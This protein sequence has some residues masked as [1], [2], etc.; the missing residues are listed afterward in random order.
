M[1]D[2]LL[3]V[4]GHAAARL[5]LAAGVVGV[6]VALQEGMLE[7][8]P[9][10]TGLK[11]RGEGMDPTLARWMRHLMHAPVRL[12]ALVSCLASGDNAPRCFC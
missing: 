10:T 9:E 2:D 8:A 5:A 7:G 12:V 6:G 11:G 4:R 3:G 1:V